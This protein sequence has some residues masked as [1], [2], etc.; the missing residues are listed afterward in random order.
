MSIP[1]RQVFCPNLVSFG[2]AGL[3]TSAERMSNI[4][5]VDNH[6]L[7]ICVLFRLETT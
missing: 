5:Y 6:E 7:T 3:V 1:C 2:S 4:D